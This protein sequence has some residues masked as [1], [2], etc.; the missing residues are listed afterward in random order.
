MDR[1]LQ[2]PELLSVA[3]TRHADQGAMAA[4]VAFGTLMDHAG[5]AVAAAIERRWSPRPVVVLCGPGNNGGDG[6]VVARLLAQRGWPVR[7]GL[8]GGRARLAPALQGQAAQWPGAFEDL[9]DGLLGGAALVVDALFGAGLNRPLEGAAAQIL[10]SVAERHLPVVAVDVPSG[11]DG[12]TG[13]SGAAI[14]AELTVTFC[15]RKPGHVLQPGRALCGQI[16]VAD[17]GIPEA[18]VRRLGINTYEIGP[19]LWQQGLI[20]SQEAQAEGD[21]CWE[22]I[23]LDPGPDALDSL[24]QARRAARERGRAVVL[25]GP[26]PVIAMPT[27]LAMIHPMA[28]PEM[29]AEALHAVLR[30]RLE[31]DGDARQ[32][33][34]WRLAAALLALFPGEPAGGAAAKP[35]RSR[36]VDFP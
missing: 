34:C 30:A 15:R 6:L 20:R 32:A 26:T 35:V 22:V 19:G 36:S 11:L 5:A 14:A 4:G 18:V 31:T 28:L 10:R 7:L 25:V 29:P 17:I 2:S 13:K 12:D 33:L 16:E 1:R 8:A 9:D 21:D 27:G 24:S 23:D 3:Q